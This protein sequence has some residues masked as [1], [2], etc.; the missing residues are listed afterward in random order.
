M[1][2]FTLAEEV[3][4]ASLNVPR[5]MWWSYLGNVSLGTI[6]LITM[7]FCIGDLDDAIDSDAPYLILFTNTGSTPVALLLSVVLFILIFAGN[8]SALATV[9]RELWAFSRDKGFPFS[10]RISH[11]S[12]NSRYCA[13]GLHGH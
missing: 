7:L 2:T 1:L 6:M 4:N 9:S 11:V 3:E 13:R 12:S 5:A 10:K 8:I